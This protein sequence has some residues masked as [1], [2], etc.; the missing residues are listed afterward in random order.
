MFNN[1]FSPLFGG[2]PDFFFGRS[3]ILSAFD[4]ALTTHGSDYRTLFI[5][6]TR[7]FGK[8]AL[9]EQLSIRAGG[10]GWNVVDVNAEN[11]L[12]SLFRQLARFDELTTSTDPKVEVKVFGSG[13]SLSGRSSQ[14]TIRYT[15][16][17][18]DSLLLAACAK[19]QNGVLVTIDE[20]QK[21]PLDDMSRICGAFQMASRKGNE[22][23][24]AVAGLP[25][26]HREVV[27]HDGCTFMRRA[28]HEELGL[29]TADEVRTAFKGAFGQIEG[30]EVASD[31]LDMLTAKS[32]GHPY[33]M[34]LLGF[35]VVDLANERASTKSYAVSADDVSDAAS[36]ALA[37]YEQRAL[38]PILDALGTRETQ[39]LEAMAACVDDDLTAS[40]GDVAKRLGQKPNRLSYHRDQLIRNG[41]ILATER[42][43]ARFG[44][45]FL[46][47]YMAK[48][49]PQSENARLIAEWRV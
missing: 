12:Q 32:S 10:K 9:L 45:P 37:T 34:Q 22:V 18:L 27:Q 20:V 2:R 47:Q 15:T 42:G 44:I 11:A 4:K 23:M 16:D 35:N 43:R 36:A 30:L 7:G 1:P 39:Y 41:I 13:G 14:K 38:D 21:I 19:A 17:D 8:T 33:M 24:L 49:R 40:T 25:Y 46:R 31:Q 6:G 28:V 5:T 48:E 29:F 3:R 26:S